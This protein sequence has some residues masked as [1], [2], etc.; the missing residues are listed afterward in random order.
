MVV[1][2]GSILDNII[3]RYI[4]KDNLLILVMVSQYM[5]LPN[6]CNLHRI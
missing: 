6:I 1:G 5:R 2:R 3:R 4:F